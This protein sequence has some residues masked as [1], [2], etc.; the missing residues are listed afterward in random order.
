MSKPQIG[1]IGLLFIFLV[2]IAGVLAYSLPSNL[3]SPQQGSAVE[4]SLMEY[5]NDKGSVF[6]KSH[7][8]INSRDP[9]DVKLGGI[10]Y[11]NLI[12]TDPNASISADGIVWDGIFS[13]RSR[14]YFEGGEYDSLYYEASV[15]FEPPLDVSLDFNG[16]TVRALIKNNADVPVE[17]IFVDYVDGAQHTRHTGHLSAINA[18]STTVLDLENQYIDSVDFVRVMEYN[19]ISNY[20]ASALFYDNMYGMSAVVLGPPDYFRTWSQVVYHLPEGLHDDLIHLSVNPSPTKKN[21]FVWVVS[22]I[23]RGTGNYAESTVT[24]YVITLD[25]E[26][27]HLGDDVDSNLVP[28]EPEGVSYS[29]TFDVESA[30]DYAEVVLTAK[31]IMPSDSSKREFYD[32]V[33]I[34]GKNVGKLNDYSLNETLDYLPV[35]VRIPIDPSILRGFDNMIEIRS[36]SNTNV[37]NYDDFEFFDLKI[38]LYSNIQMPIAIP[39]PVKVEF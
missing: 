9:T 28:D 35:S 8:F 25:S 3:Y 4:V 14:T 34:N 6:V 18:R 22:E 13:K 31:N 19:G 17:D 29:K 38:I 10:K 5:S 33:Y 23:G 11:E 1:A 12:K 39:E 20:A 21:R 37:T 15:P 36:G 7:I 27:H 30:A 24:T 16:S 2:I 26:H 32:Y